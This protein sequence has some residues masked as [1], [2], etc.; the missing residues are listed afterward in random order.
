ME[1]LIIHLLIGASID[2]LFSYL[3]YKRF[4]RAFGM[5]FSQS[6]FRNTPWCIHAMVICCFYIA[7][8][9]PHAPWNRK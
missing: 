4:W 1:Y 8:F 3:D 2:I 5:T 7:I 6:Y 9:A